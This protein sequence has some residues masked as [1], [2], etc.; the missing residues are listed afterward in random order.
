MVTAPLPGLTCVPSMGL[1]YI[2]SQVVLGRAVTCELCCVLS[3]PT[4]APHVQYE[5]LGSDVTL[6]CGTANWDAAVTWRVNG[7]DLAPD[8]LNGSQ[9][10]LHGL[11]LGHSGLYACFHRDSWH[12]H[13]QVLLHVGCKCYPYRFM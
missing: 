8:L 1:V 12:L 9:L 6:P 7:T 11:E 13:H 3:V 10:V 4:E 5:R 2:H